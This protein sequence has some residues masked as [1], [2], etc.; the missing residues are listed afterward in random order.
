MA[1]NNKHDSLARLIRALKQLSIEQDVKLWKRIATELEKPTRQRRVV[2]V[3]KIQQHAKDGET[4]IVPGKVLGVGE[5]KREVN[6]A[7]LDFSEEAK[8]KITSHGKAMSI[9]ELMSKNPKAQKIKILG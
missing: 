5:L 3:F 1:T 2:N 8:Q 4:V 9:D 7:A 6:V